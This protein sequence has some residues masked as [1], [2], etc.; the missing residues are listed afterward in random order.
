MNKAVTSFGAKTVLRRMEVFGFSFRRRYIN[1][2]ATCPKVKVLNVIRLLYKQKDVTSNYE[3][4]RL[5]Y[6]GG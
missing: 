6:V 2:S 4:I 5:F 3:R 1:F